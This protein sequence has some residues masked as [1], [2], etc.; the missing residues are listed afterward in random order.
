VSGTPVLAADLTW[1]RVNG[2]RTTAHI[3]NWDE[4]IPP[5]VGLQVVAADGGSERME[6]TITEVRDDGT[7][8]LNVRAP[9]RGKQTDA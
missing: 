3:A 2:G 7:L 6:A 4:D 9:E 1:V 5:S 8:V